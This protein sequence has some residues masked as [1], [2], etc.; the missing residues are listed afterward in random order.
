MN[1]IALVKGSIRPGVTAAQPGL[2]VPAFAPASKGGPTASLAHIRLLRP[3]TR[4]PGWWEPWRWHL[5]AR[6][7][8]E[9]EERIL[10]YVKSWKGALGDP[11][12]Q[13]KKEG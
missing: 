7:A 6:Y 8:A 13:E 2:A 11:C 10:E 12:R 4:A 9:A 1:I 3:A 5:R